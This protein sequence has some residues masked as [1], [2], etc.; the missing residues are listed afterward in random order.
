[1]HAAAPPRY[2]FTTSRWF[3][4]LC[5]RHVVAHLPSR[6]MI[7]LIVPPQGRRRDA[8]EGRQTV[9]LFGRR[10]PE[11]ADQPIIEIWGLKGRHNLDVVGESFYEKEIR[12]HLPRLA[13]SGSDEAVVPVRVIHDPTNAH[14]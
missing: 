9:A 12:A 2:W 11:N 1:M 8:R 7:H 14:D 3:E 10:D 5:G 4:F 6:F 13:S